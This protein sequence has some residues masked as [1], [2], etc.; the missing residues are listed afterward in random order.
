MTRG[1][2][3]PTD[4]K[5]LPFDEFDVILRMDWLTLHD[6]VV[7]CRRK[8]IEL[9]CQNNEI[10]RIE[11]NESNELPVVISSMSAQRCVRKGYEAYLAYV[12]DT[13]VTKKKIE[14]VPVI[15]EYLDVFPD[16]LLGL[17]LI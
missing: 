6:V 7:N 14:P 8:I 1:Y 13:K 4:L 2:C 15:C 3:F 10:F 5:I 12:L 17:L 9:K 11:S 16:E